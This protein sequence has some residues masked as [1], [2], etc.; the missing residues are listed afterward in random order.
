MPNEL[1]VWSMVRYLTEIGGPAWRD[2]DFATRDIVKIVKGQPFNGYFEITVGGKKRRFDQNNGQDLLPSIYGGA[3]KKIS[4]LIQGNFCI[5]PIPNSE[6]TIADRASFRTLEH[7]TGIASKVSGNNRAKALDA[8]RWKRAKEKAH[9]G[10]GRNPDAHFDNLG[11][12]EK[13]DIP[14]VLFDDVLTTG[15]QL[16]GAYRRLAK[17]GIVPVAAIVVGRTTHDQH[18]HMIGWQQEQLE[19][20]RQRVDL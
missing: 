18:E 11:I 10:G 5:V 1:I 4:T 17:T 2:Q 14:V 8:L 19:T 16:I 12:T 3:A 20:E 6:A 15:S 7:A 9:Q 13:P